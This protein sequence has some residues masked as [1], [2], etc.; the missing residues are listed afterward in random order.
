[1]NQ[2]VICRNAVR[3]LNFLLG[4]VATAMWSCPESFTAN[5]AEYDLD[6]LLNKM[7]ANNNTSQNQYINLLLQ[8]NEIK[9]V[10][11]ALYPFLTFSTGID[12]SFSR[13]KY[14]GTDPSTGST[15]TPYGNVSLSFDLYEE[16]N[17]KS[18]ITVAKINEEISRVETE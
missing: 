2:E 17:R 9:L 15:L 12:E 10:K 16:G 3:N 18:A 6:D 14:E 4:E 13:I 11:S 8:Q 5:L 7:L 1:M